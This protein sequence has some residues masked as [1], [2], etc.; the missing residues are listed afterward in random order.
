MN[1]YKSVT[2][3]DF[4]LG[5]FLGGFSSLETVIVNEINGL[6]GLCDRSCLPHRVYASIVLT[7]LFW[8]FG[9]EKGD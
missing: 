2:I 3:G 7:V 9:E 8:T 5:V 1:S 6:V 4:F